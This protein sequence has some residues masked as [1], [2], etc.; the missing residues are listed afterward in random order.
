M[1]SLPSEKRE[2]SDPKVAVMK[3]K[4]VV[5]LPLAKP[6]NASRSH[7]YAVMTGHDTNHPDSLNK[8]F[9]ALD[10]MEVSYYEVTLW[11]CGIIICS[12]CV[13]FFF[14]FFFLFFFFFFLFF[15]VFF[16]FFLI[17]LQTFKCRTNLP[18][19]KH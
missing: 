9:N 19:N 5:H 1:Y 17:E 12:F 8:C 13:F 10:V 2:T 4:P 16:F 3:F 6:L 7:S 14:F 18:L 15:H 11:I